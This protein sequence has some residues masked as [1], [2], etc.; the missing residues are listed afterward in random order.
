MSKK[1]KFQVQNFLTDFVFFNVFFSL[2]QFIIKKI[3]SPR[4]FFSFFAFL[5]K[6]YPPL[7]EKKN[8]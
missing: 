6:K 3:F 2:E 4:I 8:I 7:C 5:L 1:N